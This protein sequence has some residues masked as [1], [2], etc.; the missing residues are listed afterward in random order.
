MFQDGLDV[1]SYSLL[2]IWVL[3]Q[4]RQRCVH[5]K[6]PCLELRNPLEWRGKE[7]K[8]V[9]L[10]MDNLFFWINMTFSRDS[11]SGV[12]L[13]KTNFPSWRS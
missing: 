12:P 2:G 3:Y 8:Q 6:Q 9:R 7:L 1:T 10:P 5:V 13:K 11:S 4:Q